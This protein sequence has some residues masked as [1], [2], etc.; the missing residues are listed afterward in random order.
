M[1]KQYGAIF[2][3]GDARTNTGLTPTFIIFQIIAG[4]S[5]TPP[6]ITELASTG[7]YYFTYGPTQAIYFELDGGS[8]LADADRYI[9][10]ILDPIQA[11]DQSVGTVN[12]SFGSTSI[13]PSTIFGYVK[14]NL[15]IMEGDETFNKT[16][17]VLDMYSRGSSTLLREKT[18]ANSVSTTTKT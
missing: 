4:S 16:S 18:L 9:S 15:E 5:L 8:T 10:G 13:D 14:R 3:S 1:A 12:D 2:G 6:G 11:I 7:L 17:G